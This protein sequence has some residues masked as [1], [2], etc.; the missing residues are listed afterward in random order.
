VVQVAIWWIGAAAPDE[1]ALEAVRAQAE[2]AL[3]VHA[4]LLHSPGRPVDTF[5]VYRQQ[6]S[7]ERILRWLDIARPRQAHKI[8]GVSDADLFTPVLAFVFG[9]AQLGGAAAVVSTARLA[10]PEAVAH[11]AGPFRA[12]LVKEAIHELGHTF[13][14]IHCAHRTCVMARSANLA[15]VD[16]KDDLLC[17]DCLVRLREANHRGHGD[18]D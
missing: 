15:Q 5:D 10:A 18:H 6:H 7:T 16:A 1:D 3:G 9:E 4:R 12:R 14:L 11:G 13:G 2:R 8:L 17:H